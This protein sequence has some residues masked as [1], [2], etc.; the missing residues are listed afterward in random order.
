MENTY[1]VDST[2]R[3]ENRLAKLIH[4]NDTKFRK[5]YSC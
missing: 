5:I 2:R 1:I 3:M 4:G